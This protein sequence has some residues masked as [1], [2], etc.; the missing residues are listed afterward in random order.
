MR[1]FPRG[2]GQARFS[3]GT[4]GGGG[5]FG[6]FLGLAGCGIP[7]P[8]DQAAFFIQPPTFPVRVLAFPFARVQ[9][10]RFQARQNIFKG[11]RVDRSV[12]IGKPVKDLVDELRLHTIDLA[13]LKASASQCFCHIPQIQIQALLCVGRHFGHRCEALP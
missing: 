13:L 3:Q 1:A 2:F 10:R 8:G 5:G 4:R 11:F 7:A 12:E 6:V 9:I